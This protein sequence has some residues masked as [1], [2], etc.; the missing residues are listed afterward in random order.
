[1]PWA[2]DN[3]GSF[4]SDNALADENVAHVRGWRLAAQMGNTSTVELVMRSFQTFQPGLPP[5]PTVQSEQ[6]AL[7]N[8][9]SAPVEVNVAAFEAAV[10]ST[11]SQLR[12]GAKSAVGS[13][14]RKHE[15]GVQMSQRKSGPGY[16]KILKAVQMRDSVLE[17]TVLKATSGSTTHCSAVTAM[18]V[19][20]VKK[21][22][23]AVEAVNSNMSDVQH[24]RAAAW[25]RLLAPRCSISMDM[26]GAS[27]LRRTQLAKI[28]VEQEVG[29]EFHKLLL[30]HVVENFADG[31]DLATDWLYHEFS[32]SVHPER[33]SRYN[34]VLLLILKAISDGGGAGGFAS[35]VDRLEALILECPQVTTGAIELLMAWCTDYSKVKGGLK[36]L[37]ELVVHRP[38]VR[39]LATEALLSFTTHAEVSI[40]DPA[41]RIVVSR[42]FE[43]PTSKDV[44]RAH[45][46]ACLNSLV[47]QRGIKWT[48][49]TK[50]GLSEEGAIEDIVQCRTQLYFALCTKEHRLLIRVMEVFVISSLAV[51]KAILGRSHLTWASISQEE[52]GRGTPAN[53]VASDVSRGVPY[54]PLFFAI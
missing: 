29:A 52:D 10:R 12:I 54:W 39:Q 33:A 15:I 17:S 16:D 5:L 45:A 31:H 11:E 53:C 27:A 1:M 28:A 19:P 23:P 38:S 9:L 36:L 7:A 6:S 50:D 25:R 18:Q 34:V 26:C 48:V 2:E 20:V 8:L 41:I 42:L 3:D 51:K 44:V 13:R 46:L 43:L 32:R 47:T 22:Q 24:M 35:T 14:K 4:Q 21:K 49:S 37:K 40:R 30:V